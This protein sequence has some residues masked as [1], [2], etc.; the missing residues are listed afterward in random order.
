MDF[1]LLYSS[2]RDLFA[3]GYN[4]SERRLDASF[5]DLLASEARLCQLTS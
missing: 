2:T 4:V 1:E 3:I 5:Y